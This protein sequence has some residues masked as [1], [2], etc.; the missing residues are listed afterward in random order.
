MEHKLAHETKTKIKFM[1]TKT[2]EFKMCDP[3]SEGCSVG[4]AMGRSQNTRGGTSNV[5]RGTWNPA[6]RVTHA[7]HINAIRSHAYIMNVF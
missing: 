1:A 3:G 4:G 7:K 2:L 6:R 5:Q